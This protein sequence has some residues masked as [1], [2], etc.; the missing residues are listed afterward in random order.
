M[1]VGVVVQEGDQLDQGGAAHD[2]GAGACL[3]VGWVVVVLL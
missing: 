2:G 1:E 3:L